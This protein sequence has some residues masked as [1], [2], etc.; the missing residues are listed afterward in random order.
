ME[1]KEWTYDKYPSFDEYVEGTH[2][3]ATTGDEMGT[4]IH[5]NVEYAVVNGVSL[6]LQIITPQ[7][8]NTKN[9]GRK[10]P[11]IVYVQGSAWMKQNINAKLE[12]LARLAEKGYVIAV[13]EYR[14]SDIAPFPAVAV[15]TPQCDPLHEAS[16]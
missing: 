12:L 9:S 10:Y 8:R 3:I 4:Y 16:C 11:C 13:V 7:S 2:R 5:S 6:H 15:D 1:I 14:S